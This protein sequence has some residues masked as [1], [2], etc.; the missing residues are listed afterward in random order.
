[1]P[2]VSRH[3]PDP[4]MRDLL[5]RTLNDACSVLHAINHPAAGSVNQAATRK[6]MAKRILV[7]AATGERDP[8]RLKNYALQAVGVT[9]A[10]RQ[11]TT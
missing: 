10:A 5:R 8:E 6:M 3:V 2:R 7:L 11:S 9:P 1:M 4:A